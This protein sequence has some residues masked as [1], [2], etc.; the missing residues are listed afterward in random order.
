MEYTRQL[1][2]WVPGSSPGGCT[3]NPV[4]SNESWIFFIFGPIHIPGPGDGTTESPGDGL[5][6]EP[7]IGPANTLSYLS[8]GHICG[9]DTRRWGGGRSRF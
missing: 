3:E 4:S 9:W 8:R 6:K 2:Q 5:I 1:S 7:Y